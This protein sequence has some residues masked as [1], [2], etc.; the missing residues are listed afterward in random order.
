MTAYDGGTAPT[1]VVC[2]TPGCYIWTPHLH[3]PGV[4]G[5]TLAPHGNPT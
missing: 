2:K 4:T 1:V 3:I 5:V